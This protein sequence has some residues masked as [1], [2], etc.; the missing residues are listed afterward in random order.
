MTTET[1]RQRLADHPWAEHITVLDTVDS[2]NTYAKKLAANGAPHGTCVL[3]HAQ[4]AGRGRLG[5]SFYSPAGEGLYLSLI[6]R[7][8][9][10][11]EQY[12]HL[13]AMAAVAAREAL[14]EVC[15]IKP[16]IKWP[17]D[18]V[19]GTRKLAGILC[20]RTDAVII[21]IGIN[22][23][24]TEFP[25]ELKHIATSVLMA[26]GKI[27]DRIALAAALI[28]AFSRM[29]AALFSGKPT[30]MQKFSENCVTLG[31]SVQ[32]SRGETVR[33][34]FAERITENGAL[35]VRFADGNREEISSGEVSVRGFYG[36]ENA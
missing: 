8:D 2:T 21:G 30:W 34:A 36:C 25:A 14:E 13:T 10:P 32:L 19:I 31:K 12:L 35:I 6:L 16:Q 1:L 18:L 27:P 15:G 9:A 20:E 5:R 29:D 4:T 22:L 33:D 11:P 26:S 17:N 28:R 7:P 24:Q 3:A 23:A